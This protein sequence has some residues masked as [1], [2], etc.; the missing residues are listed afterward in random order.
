MTKRL[1]NKVVFHLI[2]L[3]SILHASF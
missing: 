3:Y 2:E 1:L